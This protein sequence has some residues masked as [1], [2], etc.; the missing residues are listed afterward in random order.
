[1]SQELK[2]DLTHVQ[3]QEFVFEREAPVFTER[4]DRNFFIKLLVWIDIQYGNLQTYQGKK[5]PTFAA[6][7]GRADKFFV[8]LMLL[9]SQLFVM[10]GIFFLSRWEHHMNL[11]PLTPVN[12]NPILIDTLD[13][14]TVFYRQFFNNYFSWFQIFNAS[15]QSICIAFLSVF[16]VLLGPCLYD[17]YQHML[18]NGIY[19]TFFLAIPGITHL[20]APEHHITWFPVFGSFYALYHIIKTSSARPELRKMLL[21]KALQ[22]FPDQHVAPV[23]AFFTDRD[24]WAKLFE[25]FYFDV[26]EG[27]PSDTE[28]QQAPE[29][30]G[31]TI[32][33]DSESETD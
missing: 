28:A 8:G 21:E 10:I 6:M 12:S 27:P 3:E 5:S 11:V 20:T 19:V 26:P 22:F 30:E 9:F 17:L 31:I 29:P 33:L 25:D 7:K 14:L 18:G 23:C 32:P 13:W 4:D 24:Q 1:M 16:V 15:W 2:P